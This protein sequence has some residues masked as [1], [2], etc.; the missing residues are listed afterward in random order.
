MARLAAALLLIVLAAPGWA[1]CS[2]TCAKSPEG[3]AKGFGTL[4]YVVSTCRVVGRSQIGTQELRIQRAGCDPVTALRFENP[5]PL[6]DPLGLCALVAENHL[7]TASPIA[8]VFQRL[9]VT[10]DGN[11]V[12][13]EISNA[14]Q[15]LE[16]TPLAPEQQGFFYVRADGTGLRRLGPASRDPTY[17]I[18]PTGDD[19]SAEVQT[20]IA[21]SPDD[22]VVA[23]T[24]V[25]PGSDGVETV[26]LFTLDLTTGERRQVTHL[27]AGTP[28]RPGRK[29]IDFFLFL[30]GRTIQ[31]VHVMGDERQAK[32]IAID[33]TGLRDESV[34][35]GLSPGAESHVIQS[36]RQSGRRFDILGVSLPGPPANADV[37][38]FYGPPSELFSVFDRHLIQLTNYRYGDTVLIQSRSSD[39]VFMTSADPVG[40]N[41]FHNCQLFRISPLGLGLRQTTH[42]D[43]GRRSEE[44]CQIGS[45]PGCGIRPV[46][47]L[48]SQASRAL[49][50]YSDCDPLGTNPNGSQVFTVRWKGSGLRQITHT[51]GAT[52]AADGSIVEVEIPGPVARGGAR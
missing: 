32:R 11:A 15:L 1:V 22:Q 36:V 12:V 18:F 46:N 10:N 28:P 24:D 13:F 35:R 47:E 52:T 41:P 34:P 3:C 42:F 38:P 48:E 16:R 25:A 29:S 40:A 30:D 27:T 9:G 33:G 6:A 51:R 7:G 20:Q 39:V 45:L 43:P 26:Q 37:L 17:R 5:E 8:G 4:A 21:P 44:G 49:P 14:F 50:F 19:Y 31:F 2:R 23:F